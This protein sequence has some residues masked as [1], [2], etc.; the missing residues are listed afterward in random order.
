[1]LELDFGK[2]TYP[3]S[4]FKDKLQYELVPGIVHRLPE[5][6]QFLR[7]KVMEMLTKFGVI[8]L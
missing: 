5:Y 7:C 3:A 8:L 6:L 2:L 1:V 4:K